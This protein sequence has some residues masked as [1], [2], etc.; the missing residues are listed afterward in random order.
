MFWFVLAFCWIAVGLITHCGILII[1]G[2]MVLVAACCRHI[3]DTKGRGVK[4]K[5]RS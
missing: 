2:F 1:F 3:H 5:N 4:K